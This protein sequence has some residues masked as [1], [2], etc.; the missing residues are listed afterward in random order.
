[1][2]VTEQATIVTSRN[3]WD[4]WAACTDLWC[5]WSKVSTSNDCRGV[6]SRSFTKSSPDVSGDMAASILANS[7]PS[8]AG[9][10]AETAVGCR[11]V[12]PLYWWGLAMSLTPGRR[13]GRRTHY[14]WVPF[15]RETQCVKSSHDPGDI[16]CWLDVD[17][18]SDTPTSTRDAGES[19]FGS[20]AARSCG[21]V[22]NYVHSGRINSLHTLVAV[23]GIRELQQGRWWRC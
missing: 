13:C 21:T 1:M 20:D 6:T 11:E 19:E 23:R 7:W 15:R 2:I 9:I 14:V 16:E 3:Q 4:S 10:L 17:L 12:A 8:T 5:T 18:E 22:G